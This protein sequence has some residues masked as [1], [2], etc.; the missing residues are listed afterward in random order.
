MKKLISRR[1]FLA[2]MGTVAAAGVLTACGGSSSGTASSAAAS[3]TAASAAESWGDVKLTMWGAEEDQTMLREMADA[4]IEQ[5]ADKGN[6]TIEIGVQSESSTKDTVL[7]DPESAADVFAFADDQ[8]NELVNAGALQEILL[9][10]DDIKSRNLPGSVGAAT[11]NDKLYAYP[12]TAEN[13]Y[14]LYYDA[15][16]LTAEDVQSMD[17]MLEKAAAAGKKPN[18]FRQDITLYLNEKF[19]VTLLTLP[20]LGVVV[21]TIVPLLILIAVAFT[22]YDQQHMLPAAL[23]TWVGLANFAALFGGQSLTV[24]FSYAFGRVLGWTLV[25]AFFA[26]FTTFFGGVFLAMLINNKKTKCQKLWR[27]LFMVTIAVPQFVTLLLVRNFFSD[28]GIF[29]TLMTNAG[30]TDFLKT[31]GLLGQNMNHIPFLTDQHWAKFMIVLIN[32]WV[33]VPYQMIIATGVLMNIPGDMLEAS[34]IDGASPWQS[35]IHIKL[36]YLFSVQGPALDPTAAGCGFYTLRRRARP[37]AHKTKKISQKGL[38]F[39][40]PCGIILEQ[41]ARTAE[42]QKVNIAG[43]SSLVARRAHNPKVVGSNPAPATTK[44][45]LIRKDSTCFSLCLGCC[46]AIWLLFDYYALKNC[47]GLAAAAPLRKILFS[48]LCKPAATAS[49]PRKGNSRKLHSAYLQFE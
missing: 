26:T 30:V 20:V 9:N 41:S 39:C 6:V 22:N 28:A 38:T 17:T 4:F 13:G 5:N 10:P 15:S 23:F 48:G 19:Y 8:L 3:S 31:I 35:F 24:T 46:G 36:P 32:I 42:R 45:T 33:G 7:A 27:T 25:W 44:S 34:T 12:M 37:G 47:P 11:L 18:N 1:N 14:F 43:W 49:M 21:F 16:V 2:A 40:L 29:N